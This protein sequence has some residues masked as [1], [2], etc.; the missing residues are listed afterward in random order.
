MKQILVFSS[1]TLHPPNPNAPQPTTRERPNGC[2]TVF[3]GGIP[4]NITGMSV[5]FREIARMH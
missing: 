1:C 5:F 2:R 4:E 3:V